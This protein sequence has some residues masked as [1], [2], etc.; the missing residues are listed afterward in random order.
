[1]NSKTTE[2]VEEQDVLQGPD[3]LG[4]NR[5]LTIL[6]VASYLGGREG[7]PWLLDD[8]AVAF[9]DA[10]HEVDVLVH[11]P[12]RSWLQGRTAYLDD[13]IR[14]FNVGPKHVRRGRIGK[15]LNYA[16]AGW[17]LHTAGMN[18]ARAKTYDLGIY[19]SIGSFSW[20]LPSRLRRSGIVR[21]L[22]FVLWDFFPIHQMQIGRIKQRGVHAPLRAIERLA[23]SGADAIAVMSPANERFLRSYHPEVKARTVIVPPWA[24]D[25]TTTSP[26]PER[27]SKFTAVFGGQLA[28]G[29]GVDILLEA[30]HQLQ[31]DGVPIDLL[32]VGDGPA[33]AALMTR[34]VELG[35]ANTQFR[36]ALRRSDYRKLLQTAHVGVAITVPGVSP[37]SFPSKI[38]EY[39]AS[40]VAVVVSVE[41]SS[42]AGAVVEAAGAGVTVPVGDAPA[43][44]H[45]LQKLQGEFVN[46]SLDRRRQ[47][48]RVLFEQQLSVRRAAEVIGSIGR[49]R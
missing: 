31:T 11:D 40:A 37:P 27:R 6:I 21:K 4:V 19:T 49:T 9:A 8:L 15:I 48:A 47:R 32:V 38:S 20:G 2:G 10:G 12:N 16:A 28:P 25:S 30:M 7:N 17:G 3:R 23:I 18:F 1:M 44:A 29:R 46:G 43:L 35:L 34:A 14:I 39:C 42:D 41:P 36:G 5:R 13:R 24:S 45:A 26:A 33:K 22:V